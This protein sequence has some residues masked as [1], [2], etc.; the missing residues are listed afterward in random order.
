[1]P[2]PNGYD[3]G[4]LAAGVNGGA[5][6][7]FFLDQQ[8]AEAFVEEQQ[9]VGDVAVDTT[10][11]ISAVSY[12]LGKLSYRLRLQLQTDVLGRDRR[13]KQQA[14]SALRS[15]LLQ[16]AARTAATTLQLATGDRS[17]LFVESIRFLSGPSVDGYVAIVTLVDVT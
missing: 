10:G 8:D 6:A 9:L 15:L 7:G 5:A 12:G 11:T 16:Y 13:P 14:P 1:M 17:V 2:A 3:V 4:L